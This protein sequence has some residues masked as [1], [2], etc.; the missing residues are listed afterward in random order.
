MGI[1]ISILT[2]LKPFR[3]ARK[4]FICSD[5]VVGIL[6][7]VDFAWT[8]EIMPGHPKV[9]NLKDGRVLSRKLGDILMPYFCYIKL[10]Y[11]KRANMQMH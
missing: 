3:L 7:T 8:P 6:N 9:K 5:A 10:A 1:I 4:E 2:R 11:Q